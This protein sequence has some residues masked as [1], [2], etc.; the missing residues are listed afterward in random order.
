MSNEQVALDSVEI[1]KFLELQHDATLVANRDGIIVIANGQAASLFV[2]DLDELIGKHLD[3]LLPERFRQAHPRHRRRYFAE[4][5][6]RPMGAGLH[7]FGLRSDSSEFVI[8]ISLRPITIEGQLHALAIIRDKTTQSEMQQEII[9]VQTLIEERFRSVTSL[10]VRLEELNK[11]VEAHVAPLT[12]RITAIEEVV[13]QLETRIT[14]M[15]NSMQELVDELKKVTPVF[16]QVDGI[17]KSIKRVMGII[18]LTAITG[19]IGQF[20]A[21][22]FHLWGH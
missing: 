1:A 4:P 12:T 5:H 21:S 17:L 10:S 13:P 15:E 2:Y 8:D 18:A 7:L 3:D 20:V 11:L 22:F 19:I 6:A 14:K 9:G 16:T